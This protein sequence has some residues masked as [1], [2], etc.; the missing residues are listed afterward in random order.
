[1]AQRL[2]VTLEGS[3]K[4]TTVAAGYVYFIPGGTFNLR[5]SYTGWDLSKRFEMLE[6]VTISGRTSYESLLKPC[7]FFRFFLRKEINLK[8][9]CV[10]ATW[11]RLY[12]HISY[13]FCLGVWHT[14]T[15]FIIYTYIVMKKEK[16]KNRS[17]FKIWINICS[18]YFCYIIPYHV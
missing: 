11:A 10:G 18:S 12:E 16:D 9:V 14:R 13:I 7:I 5:E 15:V 1:M 4:Q 6:M 2:L 17:P 8:I 3:S